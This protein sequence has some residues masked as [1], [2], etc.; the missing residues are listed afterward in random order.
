[1]DA[2]DKSINQ[3]KAN[4]DEVLVYIKA[5]AAVNIH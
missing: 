5:S 1:M 3:V 4:Y 2:K